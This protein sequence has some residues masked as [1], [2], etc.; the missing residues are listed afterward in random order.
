MN[1]LFSLAVYFQMIKQNNKTE[2]SEHSR[3]ELLKCRR[4]CVGG[5]TAGQV[6]AGGVRGVS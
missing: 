2:L 1:N 5:E 4:M 3:M 6:I